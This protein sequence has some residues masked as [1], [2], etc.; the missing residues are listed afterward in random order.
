MSLRIKSFVN[1]STFQLSNQQNTIS[2]YDF[3]G[4]YHKEYLI[5]KQIEYDTNQF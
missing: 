4:H 3:V 1:W 2:V 5:F